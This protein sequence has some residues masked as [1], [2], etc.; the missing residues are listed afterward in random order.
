[1][2]TRND[3]TPARRS[4][5]WMRLLLF[6]SLAINLLIA[7]LVLGAVSFR[8][9]DSDRHQLR[10]VRDLAPIPFIVAMEKEDRRDLVARFREESR[11]HRPSR[12]ET[13]QRLEA[14]LTAIRADDLDVAQITSLLEGER[15]RGKARQEA[16]QAV[17]IDYFQSLTL[18]ERR[19]YADRLESILKR[20]LPDRTDR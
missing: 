5:L 7:G 20:R 14:F 11:P 2:T 6:G 17:L 1:M 18:E 15:Q 12:A 3:A 4:P 19:V 9:G 16:G 10:G 8:G 13:R